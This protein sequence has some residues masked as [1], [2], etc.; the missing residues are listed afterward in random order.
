MRANA[1]Y[2]FPMKVCPARSINVRRRI[3]GRMQ[4]TFTISLLENPLFLVGPREWRLLTVC[5]SLHLG[6]S[7]FV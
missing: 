4:G 3:D 5:P 7:I 1:T 6:F 2:T